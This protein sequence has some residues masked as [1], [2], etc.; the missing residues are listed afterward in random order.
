VHV[1]KGFSHYKLG[2]Y[3]EAVMAY[4]NVLDKNVNTDVAERAL[5]LSTLAY[6]EQGQLDRVITNYNYI[7]SRLLPTPSYWRARTYY[8]LGE[9]YYAQGLYQQAGDMYRLVLTGYPRSNV[10]A[11][12]LQGLVASLS[13]CGDYE[14]AL[15]EQQKFLLALGN[16]DS[17]EGNNALA[18]GSI[19]FNQHNY[20]EALQQFT[21]FLEKHPNSPEAPA[22]LQNLG[23]CYYRLQ[24]YEQALQTWSD[25]LARFPQASEAEEALYRIADTQFGLARFAE[26]RASYRRL[27]SGYPQGAHVADAAFG[28]ASCVYNLGEDEAAIAAFTSFTETYPDDERVED[29]ELGIQSC[30][31]RSGKDMTKYLDRHPDSALAA[32]VYWNKGQEAFA[33]GDYATAAKAF[34]KV[35]LD[36]PG[37]ESGPGALFYLAESYYRQ[38]ELEP[39]LAGYRNFTTTH[40][41]NDLAELASFRAATVLFKLERFTE[42]AA[43]YEAMMDLFPEGEYAA[44]ANYNAAICYQELE[45]WTAAV[46][47]Y[48]RFLARYPDHENAKGLWQQVGALYQE[49]LGDYSH[50]VDAYEKA[51]AQDGTNPAEIRFRQGECWEKA[52]DLEQALASYRKADV[53]SAVDPFRIASLAQ[54]GQ[55]LEKR[56][57][58]A[59][60]ITAYQKIV[61]AHGKP[62]WTEMAQGRIAALREMEVAGG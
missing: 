42:S 1:L 8:Y 22:A 40:P 45:D 14:L 5:F 54:I 56:G 25:L 39:A 58:W 48:E 47:G 18:V 13:Q 24:Y 28:I 31:Y 37:S 19:H 34:E 10:A 44:L 9:A 3:N 27:Q 20:Q 55:I 7:A 61:D 4:Q 26:A 33:A 32:D 60:A 43:A 29:A 59:G 12:A 57:D 52:G 46:G 11:P 62:E 23:A 41:E 49:E 2:E 6:T 15:A 38:E 17:E 21:G 30:Y 16:A 51:L 36:Y 35:T 50:A 53:G